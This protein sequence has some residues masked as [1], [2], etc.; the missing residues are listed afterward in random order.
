VLDPRRDG[1]GVPRREF[2]RR[3]TVGQFDLA[4]ENNTPLL[5]VRV[6]GKVE[7]ALE[8]EEDDLVVVALREVSGD[9]VERDG[10]AWERLDRLG[11][12]A[13][14]PTSCALDAA[15]AYSALASSIL[16]R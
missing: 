12:D 14:W 8:L 6:R 15:T 9:A 13:R 1:I 7:I 10:G 5:G 2:V 16:R 11:E 3:T 4:G